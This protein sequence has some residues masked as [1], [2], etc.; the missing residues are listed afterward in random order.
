MHHLHGEGGIDDIAAGQAEMQPA[1]GRFTD[2]LR[3]VGGESND[4]VVKGALEF[5]AAVDAEGGA[6][7]LRFGPPG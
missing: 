7:S 3:D 1:A 4:V 2:V 6:V 5:F